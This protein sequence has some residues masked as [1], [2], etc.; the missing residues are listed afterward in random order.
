MGDERRGRCCGLFVNYG[1]ACVCC[2]CCVC[3]VHV[4][5]PLIF[6]LIF[7]YR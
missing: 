6:F 4:H 3:V 2:V 7:V 1:H 5:I